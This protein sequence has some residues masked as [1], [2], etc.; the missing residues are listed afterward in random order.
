MGTS[1]L[2]C[3]F[4]ENCYIIIII[5]LFFPFPASSGVFQFG[6]AP[7]PNQQAGVTSTFQFGKTETNPTG[8]GASAAPAAKPGSSFSFGASKYFDI[9]SFF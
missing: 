3:F 7:A 2:P 1:C 8:N 6:G 4:K 9:S 5:G